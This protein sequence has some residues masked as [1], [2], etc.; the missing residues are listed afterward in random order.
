MQNC[1]LITKI[2]TLGFLLFAFLLLFFGFFLNMVVASTS[3]HLRRDFAKI[4]AA[5]Q[6]VLA[7]V[8]R[9]P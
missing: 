3:W 4:A 6:H 7:A 1:P 8:S 5:I 9:R 2:I